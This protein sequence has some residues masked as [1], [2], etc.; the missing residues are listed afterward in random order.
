VAEK[1][2][3]PVTLASRDSLLALTQT[4]DAALR[5]K[6][7]GFQPRIVTLK[8]AGDLKLDAP[9]YNSKEGRAFFT[10][11]LD[12]A[13]LGGK[14]DAAVHS[15]KDLPTEKVPGISEPFFFSET[16][17]ADILV[18]RESIDPE[19]AATK[20]TIGTSSLRRIHQL[21][22]V[23]PTART[24]MLRGNIVTRLRKLFEADRGMNA[25]LIAGAGIDRMAH[26]SA[27]EP[28]K[29]ARFCEDTIMGHIAAELGKF[30][31]YLASGIFTLPLSEEF[32]PTAPGQGV[33]A[34]QM[35]AAFE[36][37]HGE[38]LKT[39]FA[40]HGKIA[41]RVMLEREVM[42]G[43][44]TGCHAPLGVSA[45][46]GRD[47]IFRLSVCFSKK[48]STEPVQFSESLFI[49][50]QVRGHAKTAIQE[51]LRP[52][53]TAFWWGF[54]EAPAS[55]F[56]TLVHIP[57]VQQ[58]AIA[59]PTELT[60][61][62][63]TVFVASPSV[64]DWLK[65]QGNLSRAHLFAAGEE[66]AEALKVIFP[67]ARITTAGRGFGAAV[68]MMPTPA[69][70]L[71]SESGEARARKITA[72]KTGFTFLAVYDNLPVAAEK[73]QHIP[74]LGGSKLVRESIHLITSAAAAKA[75][76]GF[77]GERGSDALISC[78]G[79]SAA[80]FL[81]Q[82]G[83]TPYHISDAENFAQYVGEIRGDTDGMRKR[84]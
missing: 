18:A 61:E 25:I 38:Q 36:K 34:L 73:L 24:E 5:L 46:Y 69:L 17:G 53:K 80:D 39:A 68:P 56:P 83:F 64:T 22:L 84:G 67:A 49:R 45:F 21:A 32:F 77:W 2:G 70:W 16:T 66:T 60:Q 42:T 15:F 72:E 59:A 33:L 9:L 23:Y 63:A 1:N 37:Q 31:D 44:E 52:F 47:K 51:I 43:L 78:F 8:T 48:V 62:F 74:E 19:N 40:E 27:I 11:E 41:A 54:K 57:A 35:S 20:L 7:A 14:A 10:R 26:F 82:H 58:V 4:I 30:R 71:G 81:G 13:L 79:E 29:Y 50:R 55:D 28:E 3:I 76:A 75:F 12:D 6:A 65:T